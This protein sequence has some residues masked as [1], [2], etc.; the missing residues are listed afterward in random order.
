MNMKNGT[1]LIEVVLATLILALSMLPIFGI[2]SYTGGAT[3]NQKAEGV[4]AGLAKEEMNRWMYALKK[5]N[6]TTGTHDWSFGPGF[7][8]EGNLFSGVVTVYK[9]GDAEVKVAYPEIEPHDYQSCS[10]VGESR[11]LTAADFITQEKFLDKI[12]KPADDALADISVVVTW[13]LPNEATARPVNRI[14]LVGRR[15]F[16]E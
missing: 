14:Q 8:V 9:Y 2:M 3:R 6:V 1:T 4:A 16:L 10:A 15:A 5:A 13:R 7:N 12:R 11:M